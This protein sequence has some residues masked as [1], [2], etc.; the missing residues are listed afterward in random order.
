MTRAVEL[1]DARVLKPGKWR[2]LRAVAWMVALAVLTIFS[3]GL[4]SGGMIGIAAS[5]AG[6]RP[7]GVAPT[8]VL[9]ATMLGAMVA[10][11][12]YAALVGWC[13]K[14]KAS[15]L[16]LRYFP[17]EVPIGLAI[18]AGM[19]A[20]VVA[21]AAA[22]GWMRVEIAPID[23]VWSALSD[24]VQS[25]VMEEVLFRLI[26]LRLLWRAFG[27]WPALGLS[28]LIFGL[29][30]LGNPNSSL[31]AALCIAVEAG[32]MLATFYILTGR[33]WVSI[34]VHAGWNFTQGWIF[35][36]A[37]SGTSGFAGGPLI[38]RPVEGLPDW[39]TG[40]TFGPEASLAGLVVGTGVGA[41]MLWRC[42][43][44]GRLV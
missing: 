21:I 36:A 26:I 15:E 5:R 22:F 23:T 35:G 40:G 10:T 20:A 41:Y 33:A 9:L 8:L 31:F 34:G 43:A 6:V 18:G 24:T 37:V 1:G 3:F 25:G 28:A 42:R 32:I 13:E 17:I 12:L 30:H 38:T 11:S 7:D 44:R 2:W 4:I 27:V 29:V 14:R 16:R 39:L 19:M